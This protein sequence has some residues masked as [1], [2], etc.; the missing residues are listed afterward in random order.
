MQNYQ[1]GGRT[2]NIV[3]IAD[4]GNGGTVAYTFTGTTSAPTLPTDGFA[5]YGTQENLHVLAKNNGT[6]GDFRSQ[7]WVYHSFSNEWAKLNIY[8][9]T[10]ASNG[11]VVMQCAALNPGPNAHHGI[12]QIAGAERIYVQCYLFTTT[13]GAANVEVWL[14]VNTI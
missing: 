10:D 2:R 14:G 4:V 7:V 11:A 12:L 1:S 13:G 8:D 9:G 5:N 3:N 6:A